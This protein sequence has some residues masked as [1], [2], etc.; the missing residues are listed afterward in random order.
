MSLFGQLY[1]SVGVVAGLDN[2]GQLNLKI[3]CGKGD[4]C[5][6]EFFVGDVGYF[7]VNFIAY[8]VTELCQVQLIRFQLYRIRGVWALDDS[9][10][11]LDVFSG[12]LFVGLDFWSLAN[13]VLITAGIEYNLQSGA[14]TDSK[15]LFL[16][17]S[18]RASSARDNFGYPQ[19]GVTGGI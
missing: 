11:N 3:I 5:R 19:R 14:V 18:L 4:Q 16:K 17:R 2:I 13:L 15:F 1:F 10:Y 9:G 6:F 12:R 7:K 8:L